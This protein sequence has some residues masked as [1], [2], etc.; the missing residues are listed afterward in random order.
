MRE[1]L[2]VKK[3]CTVCKKEYMARRDSIY[4]SKKCCHFIFRKKYK[5]EYIPR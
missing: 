1:K 2:K 4:C 3:I 5:V